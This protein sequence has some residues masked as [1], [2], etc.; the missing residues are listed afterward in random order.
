MSMKALY[1]IILT[2]YLSLI[3]S[4]ASKGE[5]NQ[6]KEEDTKDNSSF[7]PEDPFSTFNFTNVIHLDDSNYTEAIKKYEYLYL[8]FYAPWCGHC[9]QFFPIY[10]ETANYCKEKNLSVTFA[11]IDGTVSENASMHFQIEGFPSVFFFKKGEQYK[12]NG[13]RAKE[14]LLYYMKRKM[15]DDIFKINKLEE[16]KEYN[17]NM[18]NLSLVLLS[19]IKDKSTTI[20]K[21]FEA[22]AK[23][24]IFID[25]FSCLTDECFRKYGEDIILFKNFD[26]KEN[27]YFSNYGKLDDA[28]NDSVR[29]FTSIYCVEMGAFL[30]QSDLD[31]TFEFKKKSIIYIRNSSISE[32]TKYDTFF[33]KLAGELRLN[34]IYTFISST[35]GNNLQKSLIDAFSIVPGELPSI[36]YYDVNTGDPIDNIKLYSMRHVNMKKINIDT[37][38]NFIEDIKAGKIKRDLYSELPSE[39]KVING[40]K[41]VIGRTY[42]QDVIN[43]KK[44]V[45]LAM[46]EGNSNED[47]TNFMNIFENLTKIYQKDE[48][49]KIK[50]NFM[51]IN[52]NEPRDIDVNDNDFPRAY[53]FTNA[54]DKKEMIR[55]IP[56]NMSQLT[57]KEF[58]NFLSEKLN[59]NISKKSEKEE[60]KNK[61]N[62]EDKKN[63]DL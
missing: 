51:D 32:D 44:N 22:F 24:A 12:Y 29:H 11:K 28:K 26:E 41:Y 5:E 63:E 57:I 47:E 48:E 18:Y 58:E 23:Q 1:L 52:K 4:Y 17:K 14:G 9:H 30:Q 36:F 34:D 46:I 10:L 60:T 19:T 45:F 59:W 2:I 21:S 50:F 25:F 39:S 15:S 56:K 35:D 6:N 3:K 38:Q 53:L 8:I 16:M 31:L 13:M 54:L 33:K 55:F 49:K 37:I 43:E 61:K 20:Y 7:E 27:R 62:K 42:D 40:M